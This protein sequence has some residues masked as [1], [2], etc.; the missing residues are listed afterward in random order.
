LKYSKRI[1]WKPSSSGQKQWRIFAC[2]KAP[3]RVS[4]WQ[5]L[6]EAKRIVKIEGNFKDY[7]PYKEYIKTSGTVLG[8]LQGPR[9]VA[10]HAGK[11]HRRHEEENLEGAGEVDLEEQQL[12]EKLRLHRESKKAASKLDEDDPMEAASE[13]DEADPMESDSEPDEA[14]PMGV[15]DAK[16]AG[17]T[18]LQCGLEGKCRR[19][20]LRSRWQKAG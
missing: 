6:F 4:A 13:L 2:A 16:P 1:D 9:V 12:M 19:L 10:E 3:M 15:A 7:G 20:M 17:P 14:D 11:R 8:E 18:W 5:K